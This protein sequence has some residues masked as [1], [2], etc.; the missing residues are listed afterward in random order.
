LLSITTI[1]VRD[2]IVIQN[3]H[4]M[5]IE[6]SK[7]TINAIGTSMTIEIQNV[8]IMIIEESKETINVIGINMT[9]EIIDN[10]S[11]KGSLK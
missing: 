6:E 1:L 2:I 10:I 4:I 3:V 11:M 7:E 5:I 8:H 9:I